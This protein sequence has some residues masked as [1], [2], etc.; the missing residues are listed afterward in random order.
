MTRAADSLIPL[1]VRVSYANRQKPDLFVSSTPT[2]CPPNASGKNRGGWRHSS[3]RRMP[4]AKSERT[5]ARE[6]A[7]MSRGG[8]SNGSD[9]LTSSC[10]DLA[11]VNA[12]SFLVHGIGQ[13]RRSGALRPGEV[14]Q[15]EGETVRFRSTSASRHF[16]VFAGR[17]FLASSPEASAERKNVSTTSIF[18]R[19]RWVGI[20]LAWDG[21]EQVGFWR[22]A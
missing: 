11:P 3:S 21:D 16:R 1:S 9:S 5:A 7:E 17:R 2:R 6:N 8:R 22:F 20:E 14:G 18:C 15:D 10:A 4:P 13:A 19:W 12:T